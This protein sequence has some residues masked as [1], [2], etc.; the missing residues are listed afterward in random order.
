MN[1]NPTSLNHMVGRRIAAARRAARLTQAQLA[2]RL[3]WPSHTLI[4][5][6][7][8]R[9]PIAIDRIEQIAAALAIPPA[10]LLVENEQVAVILRHLI[11]NATLP[12]HVLRFLEQQAEGEEADRPTT[13][14]PTG[15]AHR[16][17][18]GEAP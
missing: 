3:D 11:G 5:Y 14:T 7:N 16:H 9:R 18:S 15:A 4:H 2:S 8:G 10:V 6:E 12:K 13:G 17:G 1:S